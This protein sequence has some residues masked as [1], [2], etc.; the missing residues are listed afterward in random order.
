MRS[1]QTRLLRI[2]LL[3]IAPAVLVYAETPLDR[4]KYLVE[5]FAMCGDCHTPMLN[6]KDDT[7][8]SFVFR[9]GTPRR[10]FST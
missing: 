8:R 3:A 2:S 5:S 10:F 7:C 4:G 1:I 6:G 9:R